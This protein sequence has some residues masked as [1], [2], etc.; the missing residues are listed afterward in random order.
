MVVEFS[1]QVKV[2][3]SGWPTACQPN[4]ASVYEKHFYQIINNT[5]NIRVT[6]Y[7]LY[8]INTFETVLYHT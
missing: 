5:G 8:C 2:S 7:L 6:L 4:S 3:C 1:R